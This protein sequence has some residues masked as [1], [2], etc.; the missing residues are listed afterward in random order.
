MR[1]LWLTGGFGFTLLGVIGLAVPLL[2]TTPFLLLAAWC[3]SRSSRRLHDW[4]LAHRVLGP[5][6]RAWREHGAVSPRAKAL[7]IGLLWLSLGWALATRELPPWAR[8]AAVSVGLGVSVFLLT[9]PNGPR[10]S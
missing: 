1:G 3:F 7:A 9:R 5:P 2:P 10:A 4:L 8:I 6:V